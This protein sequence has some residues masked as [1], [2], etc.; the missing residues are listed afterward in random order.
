MTS[1]TLNLRNYM[2]GSDACT[3]REH[4][5]LTDDDVEFITT[6]LPLDCRSLIFIHTELTDTGVNHIA[7]NLLLRGGNNL[8]NLSLI[9]AFVTDE[10]VKSLCDA[11]IS[12]KNNKIQKLNLSLNNSIT[13]I[14]A[15]AISK[16]FEDTNQS[17]LEVLD[18]S[19]TMIGYDGVYG[20]CESLL[21]NTNIKLKCLDL[22]GTLTLK[23]KM[24]DKDMKD[25]INKIK[26]SR[27]ETLYDYS[28]A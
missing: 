26:S 15:R 25:I 3:F 6:Y 23:E 11:L 27:V 20:L 2:N 14:G 5:A 24:Q 10:G 19:Y 17:K 28:G 8:T 22:T 16:L 18:V 21:Q 12:N 4:H 13:C 1:T 7:T 9:D